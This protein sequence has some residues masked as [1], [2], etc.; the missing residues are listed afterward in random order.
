MWNLKIN[1]E[2][3]LW[4]LTIAVAG[5][6]IIFF[7]S[8]LIIYPLTT[9]IF[10]K[11]LYWPSGQ[12]EIA[13]G[14]IQKT[15][16]FRMLAGP[17]HGVGIGCCNTFLDWVGNLWIWRNCKLKLQKSEG[18]CARVAFCEEARWWMGCASPWIRRLRSIFQLISWI[19]ECERNFETC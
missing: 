11:C 18:L 17:G 15:L 5:R 3:S 12:T 16:L 14:Y 6:M 1:K 9:G 13:P 4:H 2:A 19:T 8:D 10:I 7:Y